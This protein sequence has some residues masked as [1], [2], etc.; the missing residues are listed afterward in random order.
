[1][2]PQKA[3]TLTGVNEHDAPHAHRRC[4]TLPQ[5][6]ISMFMPSHQPPTCLGL[7]LCHTI[8][9]RLTRVGAAYAGA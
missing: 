1:M 2:R 3:A 6:L 8:R 5:D 7:C 9:V 4:V